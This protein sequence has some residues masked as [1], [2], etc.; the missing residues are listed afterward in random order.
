MYPTLRVWQCSAFALPSLKQGIRRLVPLELGAS[1]AALYNCTAGVRVSPLPRGPLC[2][3]C[4]RE[5]IIYIGAAL[6][7]TCSRVPLVNL[8]LN[9]C[10]Q[11]LLNCQRCNHSASSTHSLHDGLHRP[12]DRESLGRRPACRVPKVYKLVSPR[13][14]RLGTHTRNRHLEPPLLS[15]A[16]PAPLRG[17]RALI[18]THPSMPPTLHAQGSPSPEAPAAHLYDAAGGTHAVSSRVRRRPDLPRQRHHHVPGS[19]GLPHG[20]HHD[21]QQPAHAGG[22]V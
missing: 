10:T 21:A 3:G 2:S 7:F 15:P 22:C 11:D 13:L 1:W 17:L 6:T 5:G 19:P 9:R 8:R 14:G 12:H 20:P 16:L 18:R 4:Y